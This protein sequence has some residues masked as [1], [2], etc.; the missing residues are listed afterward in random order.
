MRSG[1]P[2]CSLRRVPKDKYKP[3]HQAK[4]LIPRSG[5][6]L[7][8]LFER[9]AGATERQVQ[10]NLE[11]SRAYDLLAKAYNQELALHKQEVR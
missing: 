4:A 9:G 3:T 1:L 6:G 2:V 8:I 7:P 5:N 10:Y 11:Q